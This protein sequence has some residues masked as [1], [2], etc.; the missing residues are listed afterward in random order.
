MSRGGLLINEGK[1]SI[2]AAVI[3]DPVEHSLSPELFKYFSDALGRPLVYRKWQVK[4]AALQSA[5]EKTD[6]E[7]WAGWN[8]TLPHKIEIKKYLNHLDHS[9]IKAG[10]VNV[11]RFDGKER[12]GYNTDAEGFLAPLKSRGFT[13]KGKRALVLGA[14]GA[15]RAVCCALQ[16][17]KVGEIIILNRTIS[18]AQELAEA[19]DGR[20]GGLDSAVREVE[21]ADLVVNATSMGLTEASSPVDRGARFKKGSLAYDLVYRPAH[22]PFLAAAAGGGAETLGGMPMLAAQAA[23]TWKIWFG[24]TLAEGL[25]ADAAKGLEETV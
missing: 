15:A 8:V 16:A 7:P 4:P 19:Y 12:I 23:A 17:Q 13:I 21:G 5:L 11:V 24:E 1:N 2:F 14:G 18:R 9:A 22:T 25:V 6:N 20:W 10:A 3:G